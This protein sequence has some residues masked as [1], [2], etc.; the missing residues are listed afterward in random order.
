MAVVQAPLAQVALVLGKLGIILVDRLIDESF[1]FLLEI[2][3][4]H[5]P[6]DALAERIAH[7]LHDAVLGVDDALD[8]KRAD[9]L[10]AFRHEVAFPRLR[11]ILNKVVVAVLAAPRAEIVLRSLI[12]LEEDVEVYRVGHQAMKYRGDGRHHYAVLVH[13]AEE[14][15]PELLLL[16]LRVPEVDM[17]LARQHVAW[18]PAIRHVQGTELTQGGI[19]VLL[20]TA[21]VKLRWNIQFRHHGVD[22]NVCRWIFLPR[23]AH[24]IHD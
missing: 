21:R 3:V 13:V 8:A 2:V 10:G 4:V 15:E 5:L 17:L 18:P 23:L 22:V 1:S 12:V 20:I 9:S 6:D 11:A 16:S 14:H 7:V 19:P 24:C